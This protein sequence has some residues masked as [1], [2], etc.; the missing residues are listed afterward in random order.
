MHTYIHAHTY[1]YIYMHANTHQEPQAAPIA[2][3][4]VVYCGD[5]ND[6]GDSAVI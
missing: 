3:P 6:E 2:P 4:A 1:T 5:F